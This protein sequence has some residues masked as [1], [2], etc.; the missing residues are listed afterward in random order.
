M[1]ETEEPTFLDLI[2][3]LTRENDALVEREDGEQSHTRSGLL[4][5][6]RESVFGGMGG[7][8]GGA[9]FAAKPPLDAAALDL[10]DEIS[11]Q[12]AE[13]LAT[14]SNLPTPLGHAEDYVRLWAGQTK[15]DKM[16]TVSVKRSH[17]ENSGI[18][19]LVYRQIVEVSAYALALSW[20]RSVE[21]Y[22][23]PP[24]TAPIQ[25][26][27]PSCGTRYVYRIKDGSTIQ[28]DALN[29]RRENKETIEA[30]C[31]ECGAS[32]SREQFGWLAT[33]LNLK[34]LEKISG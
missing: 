32:W 13:A 14:V 27:C 11:Q 4:E 20:I 29:F 9:G 2:N 28:C 10:L 31:T 3:R 21:S 16:T 12:A 33:A 5:Q 8:G 26:P 30:R 18:V 24:D 7:S 15:E 19:P 25:A 22:Y 23:T 17:D 1:T 6:L 34:P